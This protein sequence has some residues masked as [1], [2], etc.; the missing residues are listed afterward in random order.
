M[1]RRR[2]RSK[3]LRPGM[4][5]ALEERVRAGGLR[6][7]LGDQVGLASHPSRTLWGRMRPRQSLRLL[8]L[9]LAPK[10]LPDSRRHQVSAHSSGRW[11]FRLMASGGGEEKKSR[12]SG[13][14]RLGTVVSRRKSY[15]PPA[16]RQ[17]PTKNSSTSNLGSSVMSN[18]DDYTP[19][20]IRTSDREVQ[21]ERPSDPLGDVRPPSGSP[22][23]DRNRGLSSVSENR[24]T[25]SKHPQRQ[26]SRP[27]GVPQLQEP[28][29]QQS[30]G[31]MSGYEMP[32][33]NKDQDGFA[34]PPP[35]S[36]P[37]SQAQQESAG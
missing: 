3:L 8:R 6:R 19:T 21:M 18:G 1:L 37:I 35:A 16:D 26:S 17:K 28:V 5:A 32:A 11:Q 12:L 27:N 25:S 31:F 10:S 15:Q 23:R 13:L 9:L 22:P 30:T 24:E 4:Q 34:V 14:R 29:Q 33:A 20:R 36:D 2:T 7:R